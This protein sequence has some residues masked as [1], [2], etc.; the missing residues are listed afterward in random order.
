MSMRDPHAATIAYCT[1]HMLPIVERWTH[2][3]P[4]ARALLTS[5]ND[6]L[7]VHDLLLAQLTQ[8]M[9]Q[10][11]AGP[12]TPGTAAA[13]LAIHACLLAFRGD[14]N[15]EFDALCGRAFEADTAAALETTR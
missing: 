13:V 8:L 14:P 7:R 6:D 15:N 11:E 12:A 2:G 4:A 5:E 1:V 3:H 10:L 9:E